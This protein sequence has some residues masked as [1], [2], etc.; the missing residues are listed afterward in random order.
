MNTTDKSTIRT[1]PL[2]SCKKS[3]GRAGPGGNKIASNSKADASEVSASIA[4]SRDLPYV[5]D[6]PPLFVEAVM[7]MVVVTE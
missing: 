4:G 2:M 5:P 7:Q 1:S 6:T 3:I